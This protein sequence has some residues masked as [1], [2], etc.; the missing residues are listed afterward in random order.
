MHSSH[1]QQNGSGSIKGTPF[2]GISPNTKTIGAV[3]LSP[4]DG[5]FFLSFRGSIVLHCTNMDLRKSGIEMQF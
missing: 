3:P 2:N 5:S 1:L 4:R